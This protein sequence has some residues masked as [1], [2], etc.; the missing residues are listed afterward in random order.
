MFY[1]C[2]R[3]GAQPMTTLNYCYQSREQTCHVGALLS[4]A[5]GNTLPGETRAHGS[6]LLCSNN[7]RATACDADCKV[8]APF[9][10][11]VPMLSL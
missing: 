9:V 4:E 1:I 10:T 6:P 5:F 7:D 8:V 11:N 3:F 2:F